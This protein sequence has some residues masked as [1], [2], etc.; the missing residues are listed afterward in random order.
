MKSTVEEISQKYGSQV[1]EFSRV[2]IKNGIVMIRPTE[3]NKRKAANLLDEV[4]SEP[5]DGELA[6]LSEEEI[7]KLVDETIQEVRAEER[8]KS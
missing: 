4:L 2:V 5:I 1:E 6:N 7:I 8:R 3:E